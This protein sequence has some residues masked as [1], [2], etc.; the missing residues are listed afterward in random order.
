MQKF[1]SV[2][3]YMWTSMAGYCYRHSI[4]LKASLWCQLSIICVL[5]TCGRLKSLVENNRNTNAARACHYLAVCSETAKTL[6]FR[7]I[8]TCCQDNSSHGN[9]GGYA[10]Y[11]TFY[12]DRGVFGP[13]HFVWTDFVSGNKLKNVVFEIV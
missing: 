5:I 6:K 10:A 13:S 2:V 11:S 1:W 3:R 9:Q 8:S 12:F 7:Y 4:I